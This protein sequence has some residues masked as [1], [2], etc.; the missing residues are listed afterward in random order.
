[1][2]RLKSI[3]LTALL[4]FTAFFL[5]SLW[6]APFSVQHGYYVGAAKLMAEGMIPWKDFNIMNMPLGIWIISLLYRITGVNAT[7]NIAVGFMMFIHVINLI[8]LNRVLASFHLQV[9]YRRISILFYA[10]V[11][12]ST[13]ALM[14]SLAPISVFFLLN[15]LIFIRINYRWKHIVASFFFVLSVLCCWETIVFLPVL[16]VLHLITEEKEAPNK[17]IVLFLL[18]FFV[19]IAVSSILLIVI[20]GETHFYEKIG[21]RVPIMEEW[22]D[23]LTKIVILAGRCSV[24]FLLPGLFLFKYVSK[25]TVRVSW[26]ALFAFLLFGC[27]SLL[28]KDSSTCQLVYPFIALA[29]AFGL[30][31]LAEKRMCN[32]LFYSTTFLIPGY[33]CGR[34]FQKLDYGVLK[35]EQKAYIELLQESMKSPSTAAVMTSQCFEYSFGPQVFSEIPGL[36]PVDLLTT[37]WGLVDW[38]RE[39]QTA[40]VMKAID[41]ADYVFLNEDFVEGYPFYCLVNGDTWGFPFSDFLSLK[42]MSAIGDIYMIDNQDSIIEF[43]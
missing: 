29:F 10:I 9:L 39:H 7:G 8:L 27:V 12:Y 1:M 34:E 30:Q 25:A 5:Y 20:C 28:S 38:E 33:L 31:D 37:Q 19:I 35:E 22:R 26:I 16:C 21:H 14:V 15:S 36:K 43:E 40:F 11:L 24:Y 2:T 13:D 23:C 32:I 3:W 41:K 4:V 18:Y 17:S 6:I 42:D